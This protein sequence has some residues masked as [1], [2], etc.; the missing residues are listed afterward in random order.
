MKRVFTRNQSRALAYAVLLLLAMPLAAGTTRIWVLNNGSEG[1]DSIH[2][3]DTAT[4]KVVQTIDGIGKPHGVTFSPDGKLA[5]VTSEVDDENLYV[6]DTQTG[7]ILRKSALSGR[8]ANVPTITKDGKRLLVCIGA[9]RD[10]RGLVNPTLGGGG[11]DVVDTSSLKVLKTLSGFTEGHDCYTTEDGK[12]FVSGS[13]QTLVVTD[14]KTFEPLWT[15]PFKGR[16]A[17]VGIGVAPDGSTDRLYVV[18][19]FNPVREFAVVDFAA[20]KEVSRVQLPEQPSGFKLGPPLTRRNRIPTHGAAVSPNGKM[21]AVVS[22]GSNAVFFYTLPDLKFVGYVPAPTIESATPP[23]NGSDPGWV[24]WTPDSKT[25]YVPCAAAGVVQAI[26]VKSLKEVARI[27]VGKQPDHVWTLA[28]PAELSSG[29]PVKTS[30]KGKS[31]AK[32]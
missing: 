4:N 21:F 15:L 8:R 25:V 1:K 20:K 18:E 16:V 13:G 29:K 19:I 27:P 14:A 12:Y 7:K 17:T 26:D 2:V 10:E 31:E 22:R 28:L 3:I 9:A 30:M 32:R 24:T 23:A 11:L 5:Y 6:I